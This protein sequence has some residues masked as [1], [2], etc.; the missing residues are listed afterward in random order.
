MAIVDALW[1]D[2]CSV[3]A[4]LGSARA[5]YAGGSDWSFGA[6]GVDA[7]E[8]HTLGRG[9]SAIGGI[10]ARDARLVGVADAN[11]AAVGALAVGNSVTDLAPMGVSLVTSRLFAE[12]GGE[13]R[14]IGGGI[15][16]NACA[17]R[18][19][20]AASALSVGGG[21]ADLAAMCG[22]LVASRLLADARS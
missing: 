12:A 10:D 11:K 3:L 6:S 14:A 15:T 21:I 16:W 8:L 19:A 5:C 13:V 4:D 22:D 1:D 9:A 18:V 17:S 2:A 7:N 20:S